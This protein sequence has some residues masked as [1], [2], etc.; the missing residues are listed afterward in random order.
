MYSIKEYL[1]KKYDAS[2]LTKQQLADELQISIST[3]NRYM[4][5][6]GIGLPRYIRIGTGSR[7]R[8]VFPIEDVARFLEENDSRED[9]K[10]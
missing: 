4:S 9:S 2:T 3:V 8:V 7:S 10:V 1:L 5:F 6:G